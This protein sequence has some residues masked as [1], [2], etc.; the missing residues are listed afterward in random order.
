MS[1][2]HDGRPLLIFFVLDRGQTQW[3]Q[4]VRRHCMFQAVSSDWGGEAA[5]SAG[6]QLGFNPRIR[7]QGSAAT[8]Y[9]N[10]FLR[11]DEL[12]FILPNKSTRQ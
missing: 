5:P 1:S 9:D 7:L 2:P 11:I 4:C 8:C 3:A 12:N 6:V 10:E